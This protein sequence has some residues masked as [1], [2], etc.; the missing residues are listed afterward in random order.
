MT[1]DLALRLRTLTQDYHDGKL[2][3]T[4]YRQMRA[5]LLDSLVANVAGA[6]AAAAV[7]VTQ[8]RGGSW[9][10]ADAIT[11][12]GKPRMTLPDATPDASA[13]ASGSHPALRLGSPDESSE[14]QAATESHDSRGLPVRSIAIAV[15]VLAIAGAGFWLSRDHAS[16]K[17]DSSGSAATAA[18]QD[19]I[20]SLLAEFSDHGDWGDGHL[21]ALNTDLLELGGAR[22]AEAASESWFQ[23]FVEEVRQRL[24]EQQALASTALTADNSPLAALAVTVGLDLN[25]PD[26]AIHIAALPP[27]RAPE[28]VDSPPRSAKP[29]PAA[30]AVQ[31][32]S[33]PHVANADVPSPTA[34]AAYA[35]REVKANVRESAPIAGTNARDGVNVPAGTAANAGS[36]ADASTPAHTDTHEGACRLELIGTRRPLCHDLLAAGTEG[37]PLA[38]V[39]AGAFEMGSTAA[40]EEQPV[41]HV[42][43]REPFAISIY[44][45]SQAEFK[46]FC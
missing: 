41:H 46:Q 23:H 6:A 19:R 10:N 22:I 31:V 32:A 34:P 28:T 35:G 11:R 13:G 4:V 40:A 42:T 45:V 2:N 30:G 18:E 43:I 20:H 44:E 3:L 29:S 5:A 37:P 14:S 24:K 1:A 15:A 12:P 25:A 9:R 39:P 27:A 26:A 33:A 38:L 8:P 17:P 7:A 36:R 16:S 21:A